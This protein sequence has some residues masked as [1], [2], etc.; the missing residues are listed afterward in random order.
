[1]KQDQK[2][3]TF[4]LYNCPFCG[5]AVELKDYH[6]RVEDGAFDFEVI[7]S[8]LQCTSCKKKTRKDVARNLVYAWGSLTTFKLMDV[9]TQLDLRREMTKEFGE[10]MLIRGA[11]YD[12]TIWRINEE[13]N[14]R[15]KMR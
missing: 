7:G 10:V 4:D 13:N 8:F 12:S 2:I 6:E 3:Y 15:S 9:N 5:E 11:D 1:M 14:I